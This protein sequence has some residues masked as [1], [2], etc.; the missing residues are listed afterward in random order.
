MKLWA[1]PNYPHK[2][3]QAKKTQHAYFTQTAPL[4]AGF[5]ASSPISSHINIKEKAVN[6]Y[7][8]TVLITVTES[9]VEVVQLD[10]VVGKQLR[11]QL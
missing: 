10:A 8:T 11:M 1:L 2:P 4:E 6:H 3:E 7:G 5:P 9:S